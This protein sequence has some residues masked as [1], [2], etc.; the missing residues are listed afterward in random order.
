MARMLRSPVRSAPCRAAIAAVVLAILLLPPATAFAS[1]A[2]A[3]AA[4]T[5]TLVVVISGVRADRGGELVVHLFDDAGVWLKP[6]RARSRRRA[7]VSG[8]TARAEF[9]DLPRGAYAVEVFHDANLNGVLD[10]RSGP[11]PLP[12]EGTGTSNNQRRMG[13][14]LYDAARVRLEGDTLTVE[15]VLRYY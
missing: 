4:A 1:G 2:P 6:D 11:I 9:T 12:A 7:A 5:G 8:A 3:R 10:R 15:I 14:P 13:P